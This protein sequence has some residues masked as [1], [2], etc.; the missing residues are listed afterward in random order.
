M[1][2]SDAKIR[3]I[4]LAMKTE[5]LHLNLAIQ[6]LEKLL[7]VRVGGTGIKRGRP[8]GS[9]TKKHSGDLVQGDDRSSK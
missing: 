1:E 6:C 9:R 7:I 2:L 5:L 4:I 8:V 3:E